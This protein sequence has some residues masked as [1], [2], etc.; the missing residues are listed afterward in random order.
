M[1]HTPV[2]APHRA[3][4]ALVLTGTAVSVGVGAHVAAGGAMTLRSVAA[5]VPV[6]LALVWS[7]TDRER[8]WLPIAGA[9]LAG[10]QAVHAI[11]DWGAHPAAGG[12]PADVVLYAHVVAAALL[13]TWLRFGE[14]R[15]WTAA[16]RAVRMLAAYLRFLVGLL[17]H[18]TPV[19]T[20]P[21]RPRSTAVP[22]HART[23]LRHAVIRRGP[24]IHV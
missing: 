1:G 9:Q 13:A 18:H 7:L 23:L 3:A 2:A 11:L 21:S 4:R 17:G 10:Q 24:P 12:L 6:L 16:R 5:A 14:R 8:G 15:V 20:R 22:A 19:D